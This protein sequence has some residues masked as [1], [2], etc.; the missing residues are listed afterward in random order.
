[1]GTAAE[2]G[3][4][5]DRMALQLR[6]EDSQAEIKDDFAALG[7]LLCEFATLIV[8]ADTNTICS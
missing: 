3:R 1:M 4:A 6:Y 5:V 7:A 2:L 8:I